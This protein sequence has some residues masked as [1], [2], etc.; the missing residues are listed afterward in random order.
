MAQWIPKTAWKI[1]N[2]NKRYGQ[3]YVTRGGASGADG[4]VM[5]AYASL[6]GETLLGKDEVQ[7]R[8]KAHMATA[9]KQQFPGA[10]VLDLRDSSERRLRPLSFSELVISAHPHDLMSGA[11]A[12][13]LPYDKQAAELFL[14]ATETQRG[15]NA[16]AALR[17]MG[18]RNVSILDFETASAALTV[19]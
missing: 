5:D 11:V 4:P 2:L 13:I 14:V 19:Q 3:P 12:P 7:R 1:T 8:L 17:R 18:Y 6:H 10:L 16:S 15:V 9:E